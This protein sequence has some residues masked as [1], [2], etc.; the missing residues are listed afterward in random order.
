MK[1]LIRMKS[2][3]AIVATQD[4]DC[5]SNAKNKVFVKMGGC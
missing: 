2:I 5:G 3:N 1:D 4:K